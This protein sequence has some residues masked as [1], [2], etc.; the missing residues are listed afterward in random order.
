MQ[1]MDD[2]TGKPL[3]VTPE[4]L[5][6]QNQ[7]LTAAQK[8]QQREAIVQRLIELTDANNAMYAVVT[9]AQ[10]RLCELEASHRAFTDEI[11]PA[12]WREL[13]LLD[14]KIADHRGLS[15]WGRLRWLVRGA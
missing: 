9:D 6:P 3:P 1:Q 14:G 15:L 11:K 2:K 4:W 10:Q 13:G 8:E 5:L 7:P 12:L